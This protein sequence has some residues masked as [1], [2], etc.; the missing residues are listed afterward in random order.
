MSNKIGYGDRVRIE[1]YEGGREGTVINVRPNDDVLI[2]MG[3]KTMVVGPDSVT[4][5]ARSLVDENQK[6]NELK[7]QVGDKV[8]YTYPNPPANPEDEQPVRFGEIVDFVSDKRCMVLW[9]DTTEPKVERLSRL[10]W[11]PMIPGIVKLNARHVAHDHGIAK[12]NENAEGDVSIP[13]LRY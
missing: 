13:L 9:V 11:V 12:A 2:Q 5:M 8:K 7:L 3:S 10:K 1:G 4:V 6:R